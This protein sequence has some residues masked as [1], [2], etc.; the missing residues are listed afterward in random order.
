MKDKIRSITVRKSPFLEMIFITSMAIMVAMRVISGKD[1]DYIIGCVFIC[2][3]IASLIG[4][5][6]DKKFILDY[7]NRIFSVSLNNNFGLA[8]FEADKI[9]NLKFINDKCE[10]KFIGGNLSIDSSRIRGK[11]KDLIIQFLLDINK[12]NEPPMAVH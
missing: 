11:D 12:L 1:E 10:M 5:W 8:C 7:E 2:I 4:Y 6:R 9:I 3:I